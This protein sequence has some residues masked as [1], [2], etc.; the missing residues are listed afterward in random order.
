M[1]PSFTSTSRIIRGVLRAAS[2]LQADIERVSGVKPELTTDDAPSSKIA[3]M[4]GTLG[5]SALIDGLV[6]AAKIKTDTIAGKWESFIIA[7]V[8]Q[9][10]PGVDQALVIAGSDK[11]GTIYGIYEISEQMGVSPGYWWA[12]VPPKHRESLFVKA[13]TYLQGPPAVKYRGIFINVPFKKGAHSVAVGFEGG[14]EESWPIVADAWASQVVEKEGKFYFHTAVQ[15]GPPHN[16]RSIGVAVADSPTGPFVDA[17]GKAL[18]IDADTPGRGWN[19]IDPTVLIDDDGTA[20]MSWGN[21]SR[22][23]AKLRPNMIEIDGEIQQ[24]NL[25]R[26][27]EG[28][29]LHKRGDMYYLTYAGLSRG[30]ENI[31]YAGAPKMS[32]PW[33]SRGESTGMAKNS[34]NYPSRYCGVQESMVSLLPQRHPHVQRRIRGDG[35]SQCLRRLSLL[36]SR[37]HHETRAPDDRGNY[38]P[39]S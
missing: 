36:Q 11:R 20:W 8:T 14:E 37:G 3:I 33:T 30:S 12:D 25:E 24:S 13:G 6:K 15:R 28:P 38:R 18:V 31:R 34:F 26:C 19:D 17:R 1:L 39:R 22:F 16:C 9:S 23:L 35:P 29:W 27:V 32:G 10:M 7:P 4:A 21:G 5:K 2:D